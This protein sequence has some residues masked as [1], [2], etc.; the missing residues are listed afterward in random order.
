LHESDKMKKSRSLLR[1]SALAIF[2]R[3]EPRV[4]R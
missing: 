4:Y 3:I 1:E 2:G